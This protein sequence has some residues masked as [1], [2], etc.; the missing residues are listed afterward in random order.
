MDSTNGTFMPYGNNNNVDDLNTFLNSA[1]HY[2][3]T[4]DDNP[5][6]SALFEEAFPS[7]SLQPAQQSTFNQAQ[8]Q[9]Q[10]Q[11][12]ALP[13][14]KSTQSTFTSQQYGQNVYPQ[15]MVQQGFDQH[16]LA[17]PTHSPTP[18]DQYPYQQ[19]MNYGQQPF[20]Y[21][22]N[23]FQTQRQ[24]TPTQAFRPQVNQQPSNYMNSPRPP[25]AQA[26]ISQIQVSAC[27]TSTWQD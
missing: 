4:N 2:A 5:F 26:H 15:G 3:S 23:S 11:S 20:N 21:S 6:D 8:R 27:T 7:Q 19:T 18:Y 17:R 14:F 24:P 9:S 1:Q 16:M 22:F 10:S 25:Q 13:Q 12:P